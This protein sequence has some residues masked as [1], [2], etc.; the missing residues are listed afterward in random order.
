ME[1]YAA[2]NSEKYWYMHATVWVHLQ[3]QYAKQSHVI[4]VTHD[5]LY[6]ILEWINPQK[7]NVH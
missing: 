6:K 1:Y 5:C 4:H 7:Q 2:I 3:E